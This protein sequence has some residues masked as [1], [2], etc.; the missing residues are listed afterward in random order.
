MKTLKLTVATII[1][2]SLALGGLFVCLFLISLALAL[3]TKLPNQEGWQFLGSVLLLIMVGVTL[4]LIK[5]LHSNV[6][7]PLFAWASHEEYKYKHYQ[8]ERESG[9][10]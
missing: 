1:S 3:D 10:Y 7:Q 9:E 5:W 4:K 8:Y 2:L 6:M